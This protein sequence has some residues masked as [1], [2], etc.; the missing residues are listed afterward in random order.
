MANSQEPVTSA[1]GSR[2]FAPHRR[3]INSAPV[4]GRRQIRKTRRALQSRLEKFAYELIK[5][6]VR[7]G[8]RAKCLA[9]VTFRV[10]NES[11]GYSTSGA[12]RR[13]GEA[14]KR[15][16]GTRDIKERFGSN[17]VSTCRFMSGNRR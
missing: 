13:E 16:R 2:Y 6:K 5:I 9:R 8:E 12:D 17:S 15:G 1:K 11:T 10:Y 7:R 14:R 4:A 3:S